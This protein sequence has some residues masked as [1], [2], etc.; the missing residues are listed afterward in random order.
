MQSV[1]NS[2]VISSHNSP[3]IPKSMDNEIHE[4]GGQD[5]CTSRTHMEATPSP[6]EVVPISL[7]GL[8]DTTRNH[9]QFASTT[10]DHNQEVF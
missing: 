1:G 4:E 3:Q 7:E 10:S 5:S 8:L 2:M 6:L 9:F